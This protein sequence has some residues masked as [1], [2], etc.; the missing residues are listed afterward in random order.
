MSL[1]GKTGYLL[2]MGAK[3]LE[4]AIVSV[5]REGEV[6]NKDVCASRCTLYIQICK[7][8]SNVVQREK[9]R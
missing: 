1:I 2:K 7:K 5:T 6:G 3:S 8:I 4:M 9:I